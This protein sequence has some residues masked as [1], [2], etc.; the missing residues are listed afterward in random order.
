MQVTIHNAKTNL[1]KLIEAA[2]A[3]EEVIIAKGK[4]PVARIVA[5]PQNKFTIG[6]LEGKVTGDG[7]DFFEPMSE[8][9]LALW[10]GKA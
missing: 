6:L 1:S 10:E 9:D 4:I 8:D 7:P 5:I 3:G 2:K